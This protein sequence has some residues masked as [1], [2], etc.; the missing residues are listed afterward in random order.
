[1]LQYESSLD[2]M[3]DAVLFP[4]ERSLHMVSFKAMK[5]VPANYIISTARAR[6][7]LQ[8]GGTVVKHRAATSRSGWPSCATA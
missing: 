6:G 5:I 4:I 7:E 8:P 3:Q 1:M 2:A